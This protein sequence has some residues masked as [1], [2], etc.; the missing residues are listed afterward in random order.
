M[1]K[2]VFAFVAMATLGITSCEFFNGTKGNNDAADTTT[3]DTAVVDTA[4]EDTAANAAAAD[5]AKVE[6]ADYAAKAESPAEAPAEE[7]K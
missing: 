4:N 5:A 3:V 7:K 1:K 2:L 6:T